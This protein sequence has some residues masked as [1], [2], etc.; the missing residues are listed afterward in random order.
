MPAIGALPPIRGTL[1]PGQVALVSITFTPKQP[2]VESLPLDNVDIVSIADLRVT[3]R[4]G[5]PATAPE[6]RV[7]YLQL[8][9]VV[10]NTR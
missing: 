2:L 8:K 1:A 10:K 5:I 9:G 6:G 3:I 4:G 7:T